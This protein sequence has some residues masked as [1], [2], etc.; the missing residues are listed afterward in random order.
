MISYQSV[1]DHKQDRQKQA[2][3]YVKST[4]NINEALR[5][6]GIPKGTWD[7]WKA[8]ESRFRQ[9]ADAALAIGKQARRLGKTKPQDIYDPDFD[10]PPVPNIVDF[11][12][13]YLGRP[14]WPH[15]L[16]VVRAWEDQTNHTV[17]VLMATGAGKDTLGGDIV[18]RESLT[19]DKR[20]AWIMESGPMS[21]RRLG[22]LERY[23]WDTR[24]YDL[25]PEGP[26]TQ[27]PTHNIPD[28]FGI[29]KWRPEL[30]Y[31]DGTKVE[32]P[33]WTRN[34][35]YFLGRAAEA[36]PNLW[37]TGVTGALYGSRIDIAVLSD[38]FTAE[39]QM[40]PSEREKQW[41]WIHGTFL[42]R[43]DAGGRALFL[44]T[45]VAEWD[46]WGRLIDE[47]TADA[48][49]VQQ[50]QFYTKYDNGVAVVI[51][52]GIQTNA[53]GEEISYW[54]EK[55]DLDPF[56]ISR[57][58]S[59]LRRRVEL[60]KE[61]QKGL[62]AEGY[63]AERGLREF[64]SRAPGQF[65]AM[66]QQAPSLSSSVG[67]FTDAVLDLCDD[68]TRSYGMRRPGC[69]L[70]QGIDPATAAG[71]AW[72]MWEIGEAYTVI[73]FFYGENLGTI[74]LREQLL[75]APITR[76]APRY[77][78]Y[79]DNREASVLEHPQVMGVARNSGT[80]IE[81]H[82]TDVSNRGVGE[83]SVAAMVIDMTEGRIKFPAATAADRERTGQIKQQFRNWDIREAARQSGRSQ[84][85]IP[86][87]IP[88]ALWVG[89]R[90]VKQMAGWR[91]RLG[92]QPMRVAPVVAR[93]WGQGKVRRSVMPV[94]PLSAQEQIAAYYE[95]SSGA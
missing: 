60:S 80:K 8:D 6:T 84:P 76:Y 22:R 78:M 86:D 74:G 43:L 12:W 91:D 65:S 48:Q 15:Q 71:A 75:V 47:M 58:G 59:V 87:D 33:R 85:R 73:D 54:P 31:P 10:T 62:A 34:E 61:E 9:Q 23:Y 7:R 51:V 72:G 4:G 18:Q 94:L 35:L 14:T 88:M 53:A 13:S 32:S 2:L 52:P 25:K 46:N 93:R 26:S 38:I 40:S 45:R 49:I 3:D 92:G 70:V 79:E 57:D 55:F 90:K 95:G 83:L 37:A 63:R 66:I 68:P 77:A 36:D 82:H 56:L 67:N 17:I 64:R 39:N 19:R 27:I 30:R 24:V 42:T 5:I 69:A 1:T 50:D 11:R 81:K 28:D 89:W 21:E 16:P 44:G 41:A 29:Y 20:I